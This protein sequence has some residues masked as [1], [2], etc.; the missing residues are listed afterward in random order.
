MAETYEYFNDA[1]DAVPGGHG[2]RTFLESLGPAGDSAD[3][4]KM[5]RAGMTSEY[6]NTIDSMYRERFGRGMPGDVIDRLKGDR[7][8]ADKFTELLRTPTEQLMAMGDEAAQKFKSFGFFTDPDYRQYKLEK[9][10]KIDKQE[11]ATAASIMPKDVQSLMDT[12]FKTANS[13]A[14]FNPE[15]ATQWLPYLK[16]ISDPMLMS[17][18]KDLQEAMNS[19]GRLYSGQTIQQSA[20]NTNK[21]NISNLQ[22]ALG[23]ANDDYVNQIKNIDNA[24]SSY[25]GLINKATDRGWNLSDYDK[26]RMDTLTDQNTKRNWDLEDFANNKEFAEAMAKAMKDDSFDWSKLLQPLATVGAAT[27]KP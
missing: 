17:E 20:D 15:I 26:T 16:K 5:K 13:K 7:N 27:I 24:K 22:K 12:Y 3:V 21:Y 10:T 11:A 1:F 6:L 18:N 23:Y 2:I 9:Q 8:F 25:L 4:Q 14:E 19:M